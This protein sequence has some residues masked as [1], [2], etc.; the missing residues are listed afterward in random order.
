ML[1]TLDQETWP[2]GSNCLIVILG[3]VVDKFESH[4]VILSKVLPGCSQCARED[5]SVRARGVHLCSVMERWQIMQV[6]CMDLF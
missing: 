3:A 4:P 2:P 6:L 1:W 5:A